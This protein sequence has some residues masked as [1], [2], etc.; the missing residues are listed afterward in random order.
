MN[1]L[2][3]IYRRYLFTAVSI[4]ILILLFNL[5]LLFLFLLSQ[6]GYKAA[7]SY[8]DSRADILSGQ[9]TLEQGEYVLTEAAERQIDEK[10]A[11][12]MLISQEAR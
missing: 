4:S 5:L 2:L 12:A 6:F 10:L 7:E 1:D 8:S 9:L 11:F 3:K